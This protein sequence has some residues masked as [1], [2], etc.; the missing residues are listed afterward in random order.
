MGHHVVLL[1]LMGAG[2]TSIGRIVAGR[3][4]VELIDGDE[5]LSECTSGRTWPTWPAPRPSKPSRDGGPDRPR[6]LASGAPAVMG[7]RPRSASRP[8]SGTTSR[9]TP[10]SG[11]PLPST[12]SPARRS[13]RP[14]VRSSTTVTHM[15]LSHQMKVRDPLVLALDPLIVDVSTTDDQAAADRIVSFSLDMP[16]TRSA[17]SVPPDVRSG[18]SPTTP[19]RRTP[20]PSSMRHPA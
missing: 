19:P 3:L 10:W 7:P 9:G 15:T 5:R 14:T 1:G 17:G 11:S 20:K 13:R 6:C 4:G 16:H 18:A 12:T 2:K 8:S